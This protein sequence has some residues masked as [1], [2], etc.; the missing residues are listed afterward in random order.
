MQHH[1]KVQQNVENQIVQKLHKFL[2]YSFLNDTLI[3]EEIS[4]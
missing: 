2:I 4:K 3:M 1:F